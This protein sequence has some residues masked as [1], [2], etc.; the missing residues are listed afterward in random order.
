MTANLLTF[1]KTDFFLIEFAHQ[2]AKI[3]RP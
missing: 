1:S 2:F 3:Q